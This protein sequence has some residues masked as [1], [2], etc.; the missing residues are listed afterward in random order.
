MQSIPFALSAN[1]TSL[2]INAGAQLADNAGTGTVGVGM[3]VGRFF[4]RKLSGP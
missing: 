3:D 2:T 4:I 1:A